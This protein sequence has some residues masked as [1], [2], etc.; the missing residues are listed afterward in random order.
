MRCGW[1]AACRV[2]L[3]AF[4]GGCATESVVE[5]AR[6][7]Q[8]LGSTRVFA[9]AFLQAVRSESERHLTRTLPALAKIAPL[10]PKRVR[11]R[12]RPRPR[13][14]LALRALAKNASAQSLPPHSFYFLRALESTYGS[15]L[16]NPSARYTGR[17]P[18]TAPPPSRVDRTRAPWSAACTGESPASVHVRRTTLASIA[19]S[20]SV[21]RA[22]ALASGIAQSVSFAIAQSVAVSVSVP[23]PAQLGSGLAGTALV[24]RAPPARSQ[25]DRVRQ[26]RR[27]GPS[28]EPGRVV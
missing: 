11:N 28:V 5:C 9:S 17:L 12:S 26:L 3:V 8:A 2:G 16:A 23:V 19:D 6:L 14:R 13:G 1:V 27:R 4:G 21:C 18:T 10:A 22:L 20:H 25:G 24:V 7:V 15:A